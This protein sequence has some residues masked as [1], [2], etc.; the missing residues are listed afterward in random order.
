MHLAMLTASFYNH[1]LAFPGIHVS[2]VSWRFKP[3]QTLKNFELLNEQVSLMR[4]LI[5]L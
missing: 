2:H 3:Q 1:L 5:S 4:F